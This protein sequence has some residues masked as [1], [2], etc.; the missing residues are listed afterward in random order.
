MV[1]AE[2]V[3]CVGSTNVV[4]CLQ[5]GE[6]PRALVVQYSSSLTVKMCL[7][8][9]PYHM[10]CFK[11]FFLACLCHGK[12]SCLLFLHLCLRLITLSNRVSW[13]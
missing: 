10:L 5:V 4:I 3:A 8:A 7:Q 2:G 11:P 13:S 6:E 12:R 1:Q 9:I